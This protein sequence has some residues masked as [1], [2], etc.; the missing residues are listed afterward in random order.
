MGKWVLY[1]QSNYAHPKPTHLTPLVYDDESHQGFGD[2]GCI[3][4]YRHVFC[5]WWVQTKN[6]IFYSAKKERER[7][8]V[9]FASLSL[10]HVTLD[11]SLQKKKK[12]L[13]EGCYYISTRTMLLD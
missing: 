7:K 10:S 11:L 6:S 5:G 12:I 1:I 13:G 9:V 3:I 2:T 4:Y 8:C